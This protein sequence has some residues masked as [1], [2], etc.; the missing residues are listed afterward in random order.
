MPSA[1]PIV[2]TATG[3]VRG[4]WRDGSAA[5]LGIPFA[6][7]FLTRRALI[8]S[9]GRAWFEAHFVPRI[10]PVTLVALLATIVLMFSLKGDG[11]SSAGRCA[12]IGC[13]P[14]TAAR[15]EALAPTMQGPERPLAKRLRG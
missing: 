12:R 9:R 2:S 11:A 4:A 15:R 8:A 10:G 7:G 13:C 6:A 1:D 14:E 3:R 5:F